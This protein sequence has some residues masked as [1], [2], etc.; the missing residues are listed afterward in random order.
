M[1][2]TDLIVR[3]LDLTDAKSY[4]CQAVLCFPKRGQVAPQAITFQNPLPIFSDGPGAKRIGFATLEME[5]NG[6]L[7][8]EIFLIRDSP[9]R[10]DLEHGQHGDYY[11]TMA[12]AHGVYRGESDFKD[13]ELVSVVIKALR[14]T[15][16]AP[17]DENFYVTTVGPIF[18]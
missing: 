10:L 11:L 17:R 14:L 9:E 8:A 7:D 2:V 13:H 3:V 16:D 12:D 15:R 6:N 1:N 5:D 18:I 4:H